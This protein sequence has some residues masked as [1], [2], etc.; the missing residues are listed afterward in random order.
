MLRL[1]AFTALWGVLLVADIFGDVAGFLTSPF[2]TAKDL[3][4][5]V[6]SAIKH[7]ISWAKTVFRNVGAAWGELHVAFRNL[8]SGLEAVAEGAYSSIRFL[9]NTLV[10]K[11]VRKAIS[12]SIDW[13]ER[14]IKT[15]AKTAVT[16]ANNVKKWAVGRI[17]SVLSFV[18]GHINHLYSLAEEAVNWV[19]KR[20]KSVWD[21][22]MH[23]SKLVTHILPS[24]VTPLARWILSHL[25]S[26]SVLVMRSF[27]SNIGKYSLE[28]ERAIRQV[29]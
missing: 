9:T 17:N 11:W 26:L 19:R 15:I 13:A 16:L 8:I 24:L 5:K 20:G 4:G 23:P 27:F 22:V 18:R 29:F 1:M 10:P 28:I 2:R 14:N 12:D 25:E 3:A 6:W 21:L 7:V